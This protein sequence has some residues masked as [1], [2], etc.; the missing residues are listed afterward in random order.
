[1]SILPTWP[2]AAGALAAG[3]ALGAG[4]DHLW[5]DTRLS[6]EET[7]YAKL[8]T[9]QTEQERQ[10]QAQRALDERKAREDEQ[11]A[12]RKAAEAEQEKVNE[13]ARIRADSAAAIARVSNRPDRKPTPASGL[14]QATAA[15][16]GTT[17]AE[18]SRSDAEFLIGEAARADNLR[19]ALSAC[20]A[21]YD[22]ARAEPIAQ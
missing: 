21:V 13:I 2:I 1:M 15:C 11:K 16:Q 18:L 6:R 10:R 12:A 3:I 20:Y 14:P 4:A 19:A 22:A 8:V 7:R 9:G 17:G 5:M